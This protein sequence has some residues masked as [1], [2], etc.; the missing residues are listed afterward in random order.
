MGASGNNRELA[1]VLY[2]EV[3][4]KSHSGLQEAFQLSK[5]GTAVQLSVALRG[6]SSAIGDRQPVE[7][8]VDQPPQQS[9]RSETRSRAFEEQRNA[10]LARK[11]AAAAAQK[12][13]DEEAEFVSRLSESPV[14]TAIMTNKSARFRFG[15]FMK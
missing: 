12:A 9:V 4:L 6:L 1:I 13:R 5:L 7:Q 15:R 11:A 8:P 2:E 14:T 10:N 3:G